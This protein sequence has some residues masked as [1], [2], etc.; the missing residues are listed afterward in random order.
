VSLDLDFDP[1]QQAIAAAV[2]GFCAERC[3]DEIVKAAGGGLPRDLWRE[4]AELG[5]L[6]LAT[7]HGEGGALEVVAAV[8]SLGRAVFPG[9]L[10]ASFLATQ[11]LPDP[12]RAEIAAGA[13]IVSAGVPPLMPWAACA[14]LLLEIDGDAVF[15]CQPLCEV[16]PVEMLGGEPWGR[17]RLERGSPLPSARRGLLLS[18][19]V[20]AAQLG[21]MGSRL[22]E[23]AS[24]HAAVRKQFGVP[25]GDFQAVA[26][27]LADCTIQLAAAATLARAA[28]FHFD[29]GR[30]DEARVYAASAQLSAC[31]ASVEAAY[32]CHQVFGAIGITL[33]GPVFHIS[34]RIRLLASQPPTA[35]SARSDLLALSEVAAPLRCSAADAAT[36]GRG[37]R[38]RPRAGI[39]NGGARA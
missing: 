20:L 14:D 30:L 16:E 15:P 19:I 18:R 36:E 22:V 8:E 24:A 12:E 35:A 11:V 34:R 17:V 33:G 39:G 2:A 27:P 10:V 9:P 37:G 7:P 1:G 21:A 26:H 32:V 23:D 3:S 28:A 4:L 5:V 13:R 29:A 25:I 38:A 31:R 6:G